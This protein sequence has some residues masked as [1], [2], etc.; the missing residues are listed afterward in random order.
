MWRWLCDRLVRGCRSDLCGTN[1]SNQERAR[2]QPKPKGLAK[3]GQG[4]G[5]G[6]G[7]SLPAVGPYASP[8]GWLLGAGWPLASGGPI[9]VLTAKQE[10]RPLP[11]FAWL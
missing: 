7:N 10:A 3:L 9:H 11:S 4:L 5:L 8:S 1:K 2:S 6:L